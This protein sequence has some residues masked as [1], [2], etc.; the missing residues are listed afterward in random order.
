MVNFDPAFCR[1][2]RAL[3]AQ[4]GVLPTS[5]LTDVTGRHCA[6][7]GRIQAIA[8]GMKVAGPAFTV[9]VRPGDNLAIHFALLLAQPGDV[10]VVDGQGDL[11]S[12]LMGELMCAHAQKAGIAGVVIDGAVRDTQ[13]LRAG[14]LPVF[15]CGSS[16]NGPTRNLAGR[17]AVPVSVGGIQVGPGDL[18]VGDGDGV[19]A[20]PAAHVEQA[21][22]DGHDK[23]VKEARRR[24]D[25]AQG[26][27]VYG[28]L[29][30]ALK[31]NDMLPKQACLT[32]VMQAFARHGAQSVEIG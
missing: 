19:I 20:L 5:V 6:L 15:A 29:E 11:R 25:I 12:A 22:A 16:P 3:A 30:N 4:A 26:N 13:E 21:I 31:A 24:A 23:I 9:A 7:H 32:T 8:P 28:W 10:L 14:T 27:V 18:I 1:V 17:V 2:S